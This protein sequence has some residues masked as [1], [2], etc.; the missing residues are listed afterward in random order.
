MRIENSMIMNEEL[1]INSR[2]KQ[3]NSSQKLRYIG[4]YRKFTTTKAAECGG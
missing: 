1:R 3:V 4:L 2:L